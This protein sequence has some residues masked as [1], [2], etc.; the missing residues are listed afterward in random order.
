MISLEIKQ[1]RIVTQNFY[2][3]FIFILLLV[4][5]INLEAHVESS[6]KM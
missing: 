5:D 3:T 6:I 2:F 4:S 1:L